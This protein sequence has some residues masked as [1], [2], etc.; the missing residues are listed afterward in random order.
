MAWSNFASLP[1]LAVAHL[2]AARTSPDVFV[3]QVTSGG[4]LIQ[5]SYLQAKTGA[6]TAPS[7]VKDTSTLFYHVHIPRTGG[8]TTAQLLVSDIC[9]PFEPQIQSLYVGDQSLCNHTCD[10]GLT[11]N[12]LACFPERLTIEHSSFSKNRIRAQQLMTT[13]GATHLIFVTTLRRGSDR[14]KSQWALEVMNRLWTPPPGVEPLSNESLQ[15]YATG[16]AHGGDGWAW[17]SKGASHRNN[18]QVAQLAS[19]ESDSPE[20]M[21]R[22]HLEAAKQVLLEAPA[23]LGGNWLI[24]FT[25]CLN[26]VHLKLLNYAESFHG[27]VPQKVMPFAFGHEADVKHQDLVLNDETIDLLDKQCALDNELFEWAWKLAEANSDPRFAGTC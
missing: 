17:S 10:M 23:V 15:F 25:Q 18:L 14:I 3:P 12:E 19:V 1:F 20:V 26:T 8:T 9:K 2:A 4:S 11:D 13:S 27:S 7:R 22:Q 24:G 16:G 6:L 21:S 5:K